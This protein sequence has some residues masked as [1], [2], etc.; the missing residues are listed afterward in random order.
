MANW[1][2][3]RVLLLLAILFF[4]LAGARL[5]P[6]EG[7]EDDFATPGHPVVSPSGRYQL[8]VTEGFDGAV[9]FA[10]FGIATMSQVGRDPVVEFIGPDSFRARD[11]LFFLW[12]KRD[13]VWVYSGDLGTFYWERDG[14]EAKWQKR[15]YTPG[16]IQ[17]PGTLKKR[18]KVF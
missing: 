9:R 16:G 15:A 5:L 4:A 3:R 18:P 12:G 7:L 11:A 13:R 8:Q 1:R 10:R 17:V 14:E 6:N 2:L